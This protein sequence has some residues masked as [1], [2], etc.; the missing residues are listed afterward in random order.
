MGPSQSLQHQPS[1]P[2]DPSAGCHRGVTPARPAHPA[3]AAQL[4]TRTRALT[5]RTSAATA[6]QRKANRAATNQPGTDI[7]G[8]RGWVSGR[9]GP[10]HG[11]VT[12]DSKSAQA[13]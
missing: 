8:I 7:T 2:S 13:G 6:S 4:P 3:A 12:A 5:G 9:T 1:Q 10:P 11:N